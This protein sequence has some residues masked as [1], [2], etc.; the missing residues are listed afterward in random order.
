VPGPKSVLAIRERILW[1]ER[2]CLIK[3]NLAELRSFLITGGVDKLISY[4]A[5]MLSFFAESALTWDLVIFFD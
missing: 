2:P 3:T 5:L 4:F 1:F